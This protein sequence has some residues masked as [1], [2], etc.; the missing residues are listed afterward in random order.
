MFITLTRVGDIKEDINISTI[1]RYCTF[2]DIQL[3]QNVTKIVFI[4]GDY[5]YYHESSIVIRD[6]INKVLGKTNG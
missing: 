3:N 6:S 4:G 1:V 2:H 5:G